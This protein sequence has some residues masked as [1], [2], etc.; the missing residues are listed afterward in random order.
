MPRILTYAARKLVVYGSAAH[1][2]RTER[3]AA[4]T[5]VTPV[6]PENADEVRATVRDD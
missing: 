6:S 1:R 2:S 4:L 3:T 5:A